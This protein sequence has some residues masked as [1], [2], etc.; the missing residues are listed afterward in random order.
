MIIFLR[1]QNIVALR[2]RILHC[3]KPGRAAHSR[4]CGDDEIRSQGQFLRK[5][6]TEDLA[7]P[8]RISPKVKQFTFFVSAKFSLCFN[9]AETMRFELMKVLLPCL[10]SS[11]VPSTSSATSPFE[12]FSNQHTLYTLLYFC[13]PDSHPLPAGSGYLRSQASRATP[14]YSN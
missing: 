3:A 1:R 5:L 13:R 11:E 6:G 8:I 7:T 10:V 4:F 12:H 2:A 9:F 14:P